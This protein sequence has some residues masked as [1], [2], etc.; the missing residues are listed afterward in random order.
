MYLLLVVP[1]ACHVNKKSMRSSFECWHIFDPFG[2]FG[3]LY[4]TRTMKNS[5]DSEQ[6]N[7]KLKNIDECIEVV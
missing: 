7:A 1:W 3:I 6:E 5:I 2:Y 4:S